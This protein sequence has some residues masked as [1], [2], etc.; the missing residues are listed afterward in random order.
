MATS[1]KAVITDE[2]SQP[3]VRVTCAL[4][5]GA[6]RAQTAV[7]T[8]DANG[9]VA[10]TG[11]SAGTYWIKP[12]VSK[13]TKVHYIE[14]DSGPIT[15]L[16]AG[17][18]KEFY[19]SNTGVITEVALGASGTALV[20]NG[21][22][23]APTM[24]AVSL[25]PHG[26]ADHTNRTRSIWLPSQA[27]TLDG[28]TRIT[29]GASPNIIDGIRMADGATQGCYT[30]FYLPELY[31]AGGTLTFVSHFSQQGTASGAVSLRL[32]PFGPMVDGIDVTG[33]PD[34]TLLGTVT[35]NGTA[36][37]MFR[38]SKAG[39]S[40]YTASYP[41]MLQLLRAGGDAGDTLTTGL[42]F[43]GMAILFTADQ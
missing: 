9:Y 25:N 12:L 23:S 7:G 5:N 2:R 15:G 3:A 43:H 6:S 22:T 32:S 14:T 29:K 16:T 36:N 31:V 21:A 30:L 24:Q 18:N 39:T 33:G 35:A 1:V 34:Q 37:L 8:T 27:F 42:D 4:M 13:I 20:S 17:N 40:T 38:W 11:L 26:A 41:L 10:F 28:A 19:S